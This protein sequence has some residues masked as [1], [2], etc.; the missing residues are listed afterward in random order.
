MSPDTRAF[1]QERKKQLKTKYDAW[2]KTFA[3]WKVR[4]TKQSSHSFPFTLCEGV[5]SLECGA[6]F[7]SVHH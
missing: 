2:N 5:K 1:F 4:F 3:E 6:L 7:A